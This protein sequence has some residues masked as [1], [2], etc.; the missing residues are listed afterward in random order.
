MIGVKPFDKV[1]HY[2]MVG[3]LDKEMPYI[4]IRPEGP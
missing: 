1:S 2:H 3:G 4:S